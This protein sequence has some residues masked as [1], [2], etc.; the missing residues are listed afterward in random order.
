MKQK[1]I[2]LVTYCCKD[3]RRDKNPLAAIK[4]YK[5]KRIKKVFDQAEQKG[6]GMFIL[7]GLLG[8]I[9][10]KKRIMWYDK[11]L[12]PNDVGGLVDLVAHQ[13]LQFDVKAIEYITEDIW[14]YP[15]LKPYHDLLA[16]ACKRS[17]VKMDVT[18]L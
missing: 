11:L 13:L 5:S 14:L 15:S 10:P 7:S 8:L 1:K 16:A 2:T 18:P 12:M 6:C 3:K 17:K 9:Q 4:R